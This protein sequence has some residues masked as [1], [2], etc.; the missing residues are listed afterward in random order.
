[1][2]GVITGP[3]G[4]QIADSDGDLMGGPYTPLHGYIGVPAPYTDV[5]DVDGTQVAGPDG[6]ILSQLVLGNPNLIA[7]LQPFFVVEIEASRPGIAE[8]PAYGWGAAPWGDISLEAMAADETIT[9]RA[10]DLGYHTESP[11]S[12]YAPLLAAGLTIDA[13][14]PLSPAQDGIVYG[15]GTISLIN[16]GHQYDGL[17]AQWNID[18][19][20]V[21]VKYGVKTWDDTRGICVDPVSDDLITLFT[22]VAGS[23]VLSEFLLTITLRDASYWMDR[24]LQRSVYAG[25]GT[26]EGDAELAGTPKPK[27]RG[28]AFNVPLTLIDR[29]NLIYQYNDGPG[30]VVALYQGAATTISF[31][32]DTTDLYTGTTAPGDYR[33]DNSRGLIQLGLEPADNTALTATV[34]GHF[35]SAGEQL[36]AA[37][38]VRYLIAEDMELPSGLLDTATF[39]TAA[40]DYPYEAGWYWGPDAQVSGDMAA[41]D[42]LAAFG[43]KIAPA[44]NGALQ[45]IVLKA[46]TDDEIPAAEYTTAS[47]IDCEPRALPTDIN[48]PPR[49]I[50][51]AFQHNYTVQQNGI[52]ES[53]TASHRQFVQQS[54]RYA[55]WTSSANEIAYANATDVAPFG[56]GLTTEADAQEVANR[57][58]ALFGARRWLFDLKLPL[59]EAVEREFGEVVSVTYP[60][61][62]MATSS[63]VRVLGRSVDTEQLSMTLTVLT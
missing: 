31:D 56:G 16:D 42:C 44:V 7:G 60:N 20:T 62:A 26:Y 9:I 6:S 1:M 29:D 21:R 63:R 46:V 2:S 57:Y 5:V 15:F 38:I 23:W 22:G 4:F 39:T 19:R 59:V 50:R 32:A 28:K 24:P 48:P 30:T 8:T 61:H 47:I 51:V 41:G 13:R 53:A 40:A 37:N 3:G 52:L 12:V 43:A 27:T 11:V 14:V 10:S 49:R 35:P 17:M 54:D 25:T 33:T 34:I 45:C 36:I 55:V 58:G 18:G